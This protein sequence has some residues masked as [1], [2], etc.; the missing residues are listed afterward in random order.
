[1]P[2]LKRK[3]V[4]G[5]QIETTSGTAETID[6]ADG[7]H[8]VYDLDMQPDI[9]YIERVNQGAFGT[10]RGQTGLQGGTCKFKTDVYGDDAGGVPGW[11]ST[12]LPA[13]GWV[14]SAGVFS[15]KSETPGSNVKTLTISGWV[16]GRRKLMVGCAGTFK[17]M[18]ETGKPAYI[19]WEFKG[20]WTSVSDT[21]IIAPT[22]PSIVPIKVIGATFTLGSWAPC[23]AKLEIDAGNEVILR[24][25]Q[26]ATYGF[27]AALITNRM[28]KGTMDPESALVAA[29]DPYGDMIA[30][31]ERALA[32]SIQDSNDKFALAAPKVQITN[33]SY[34][35]RKGM[36]VDQIAFACNRSA[37]AGNDELTITFSAP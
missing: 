7:A 35:D 34:A 19:E 26:T 20:V 17:M 3:S 25:C 11:A 28:V 2:L 30:G 6:A 33:V 32:F 22:Y 8:N 29:A 31:T 4:L 23:W 12:F 15:P 10:R 13:C 1:M 18:F 21:T 5:A 16:E 9:E 36:E 14:N 27:A 24:E 37:A